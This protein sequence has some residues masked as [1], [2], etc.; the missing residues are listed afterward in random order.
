MGS[1]RRCALETQPTSVTMKGWDGGG[2]RF[3]RGASGTWMTRQEFTLPEAEM[4]SR[5]LDRVKKLWVGWAGGG[6]RTGSRDM[7]HGIGMGSRGF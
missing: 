4:F 3:T 1:G 2:A 7:L 6:G 5:A